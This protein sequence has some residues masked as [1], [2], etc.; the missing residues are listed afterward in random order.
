MA[1]ITEEAYL[2]GLKELEYDILYG[3]K[4]TYGGEN[5]YTPTDMQMGFFPVTIS[6]VSYTKD[7]VLIVRGENF[8]RYSQV[9]ITALLMIP[10]IWIRTLWL[11]PAQ[12]CRE[13]QKLQFPSRP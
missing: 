4:I 8:T 7:H 13:G 6:N 11:L 3:D 9:H 12:I 10:C 2:S 5:P 1:R